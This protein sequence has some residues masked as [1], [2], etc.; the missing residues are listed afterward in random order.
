MIALT[1]FTTFNFI[2]IISVIVIMMTYLVQ[3]QMFSQCN[4]HLIYCVWQFGGA[5]VNLSR[6]IHNDCDPAI[7]NGDTRDYRDYTCP[8]CLQPRA[9]TTDADEVLSSSTP[10]LATDGSSGADAPCLSPVTIE[11]ATS[12]IGVGNYG[13][14]KPMG[15]MGAMGPM[16]A[17]ASR[18]KGLRGMRRPRGAGRGQVG[19]PPTNPALKMRGL[20]RWDATSAA[21][22]KQVKK[23]FEFERDALLNVGGCGGNAAGKLTDE[24]ATQDSKVVLFS[25][26]DKFV[27]LQDMCV[28][29]GSFG[30]GEEGRLISCAQCGQCYHPYCCG[31]KVTQTTLTKGW[32]CL[33]CTVCEGC[34]QPHD[35]SRLLLCDDCDTS[36]HTYCLKP[37]LEN[38]PQGTWKCQHCVVC[39]LCGSRS[40][41]PEGSEWQANYTEC[42]P[43]ASKFRCIQCSQDY[44]E[45]DIIIECEKCMRWLHGRC[46]EITCEEDAERCCD[47]GYSCP[48]CRGKD[49]LPAHLVHDLL[50]DSPCPSPVPQDT[51]AH[52]QK[53]HHLIDG[54]YLTD[55][56]LNTIKTLTLEP[57]K[58]TRTVK[59]KDALGN[60]LPSLPSLSGLSSLSGLPGLGQ[61]R[62]T[63]D[64]LADGGD[65]FEFEADGILEGLEGDEEIKRKKKIQ[66]LGIGGFVAN[67]RSRAMSSKDDATFAVEASAAMQPFDDDKETTSK[68]G[69][70]SEKAQRQQRRRRPKKKRTIE[71]SMPSHIQEAFFGMTLLSATSNATTDTFEDL[72]NCATDAP[73]AEDD[74]KQTVPVQSHRRKEPVVPL[75]ESRVGPPDVP[76][77]STGLQGAGAGMAAD[78]SIDHNLVDPIEYDE[79]GDLLPSDL[80]QE[81]RDDELMDM[82][83]QVS[84]HNCSDDNDDY[85]YCQK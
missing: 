54:V 59:P 11:E 40:P 12:A 20:G 34:G 70:D 48:L 58:R 53:A 62:A 13:A 24:E 21:Q 83:M 51:P 76:A 67:A 22:A 56:G 6:Y 39:V 69:P 85:Y 18:G 28:L 41:G 23:D 2:S 17:L 4:L 7:T 82:I 65:P 60:R 52:K 5:C 45:G 79:L 43:C 1:Y 42:A 84:K 57:P 46:D 30:I 71:E 16:G 78:L 68:D 15:A 37:P 64:D 3:Q 35:E 26:N 32:R 29:C 19:R 50:M 55:L 66:K 33:D 38:V 47:L 44:Q 61:R 74:R 25:A 63:L 81:L 9:N 80:P 27:L 10:S 31:A 75:A 8:P 77:P 49:T 73:A 36:Y 14:G 72:D